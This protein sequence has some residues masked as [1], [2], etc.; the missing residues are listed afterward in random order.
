MKFEK[1]ILS[2]D[3]ESD[4]DKYDEFSDIIEYT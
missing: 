1:N 2:A 4:D 3:W